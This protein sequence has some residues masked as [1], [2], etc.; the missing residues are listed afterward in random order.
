ME[1]IVTYSIDANGSTL[2]CEDLEGA[3][4]AIRG[5]MNAEDL[6]EDDRKVILVSVKKI[7]TAEYLATL[8]ESDD[9]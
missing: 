7:H 1:K 2:I 8:E 5:Q 4:D 3:I 9:F 6:E